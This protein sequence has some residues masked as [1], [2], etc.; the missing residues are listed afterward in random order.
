MAKA[1]LVATPAATGDLD[2]FKDET[3]EFTVRELPLAERIAEQ[4]PV[5]APGVRVSAVQPNGWTALAGIGPG[6]IVVSIDGQVVRTVAEAEKLLKGFRE[7]KPK[8]VVFFIRRGVGS[9]FA[10]VEPRW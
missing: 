1:T 8:H 3:F 5:D 6:D 9:G 2:T 7:K 10:E 4:L